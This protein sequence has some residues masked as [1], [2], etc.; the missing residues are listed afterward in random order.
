[1]GPVGGKF[2]GK[3]CKRGHTGLRYR[4]NGSCVECAIEAALR[5]YHEVRRALT[6]IRSRAV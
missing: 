5:R 6:L 4:V 1:M 3:P 2:Q